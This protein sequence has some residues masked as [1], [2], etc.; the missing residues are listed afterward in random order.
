MPFLTVFLLSYDEK[1]LEQILSIN[2]RADLI[3][4]NYEKYHSKRALGFC[5]SR[6][7]AIFMSKYFNQKNIK[8][9][10]VV[11]GVVSAE[12][13]QYV[14]DDPRLAEY[15][16]NPDFVR[17]FKDVLAFKMRRFYKE[18]LEKIYDKADDSCT[19]ES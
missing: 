4:D 8:A 1:Q 9:A 14:V 13:R 2:S 10:A 3:F 15:A 7:H 5:S 6:N 11:S 12:N 17:H 19:N 16:V 18:R